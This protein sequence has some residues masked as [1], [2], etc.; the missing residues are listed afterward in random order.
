MGPLRRFLP[1]L[2]SVLVT[3]GGGV[4]AQVVPPEDGRRYAL[5]RRT[6]PLEKALIKL[7]EAGAPLSYRPDLI[8]PLALRC[9]GGRRTLDNW[10]TLLLRDTDLTYERSPAGYLIVPDPELRSKTFRL[11][12]SL[13]ERGSGEP[14]IGAAVRAVGEP[15]GPL[16]VTN[17]FG[18]YSLSLRGG[19]QRVR[20]SH[21]GYNPLEIDVVLRADS[22]LDPALGAN[23]RLPQVIVTAVPDSLTGRSQT[24][25]HIGRQ[26]ASQMAGPGGQADPLRLARLL[27]GVTSGADGV[28]GLFVRGSEAGHNLVLLDGVPV[29]NLSHAAGLF[30]IFSNEAVNRLDLYKDAVPA[31]FGGR[32]GGVLDVHTRDGNRSRNELSLGTNLLSTTVTAEGPLR[33]GRSSFLLTGRY[34]WATHLLREFSRRYKAARDR[35]GSTDYRVYDFN[36]KYSD[37]LSRRGHLYLSAYRGRDDYRNTS[38]ESDTITVLTAQ[39][40]AFRYRTPRSRSDRVGWVNTVAALRYNHIFSDRLFTNFRLSYSDLESHAVT[41]RSDSIKEVFSA[42]YTG[43]AFQG[44]YRSRIRQG[45]L[46]FDGEYGLPRAGRLTFGAAAD[47]HRFRPA[48]RTGARLPEGFGK[49]PATQPDEWARQLT[50]YASWEGH[51]GP[52]FIRAGSRVQYWKNGVG[53]LNWSPRLLLSGELSPRLSWQLAYD[54]TVQAVHLLS[55]TVI[56]LP[57]NIWVPAGAGLPP[58]RADQVSLQLDWRP[59]PDWQ[60]V[61]AGYRKDFGQLVT[62]AESGSITDWRNQ[63]SRGQGRAFGSELTLRRRRGRLRGWVSYALARSDRRFDGRVNLGRPFPFRFDRRHSVNAVGVLQLGPRWTLSLT[64]RYGSGAAYSLS[65]QSIL[66]ADPGAPDPEAPPTEVALFSERNGFRLPPNHRLDL[67]FHAEIRRGERLTHAVDLGLYNVYNRHNPIYY[68]VRSH[69]SARQEQL[70]SDREFVQVYI[71]PLLPILAYRVA[72]RGR[73]RPHAPPAEL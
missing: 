25:V 17:A 30:S 73:R 70:R 41:E 65:R 11:Y 16:A 5:P 22:L 42:V 9:P 6:L 66:I 52:L 45:G 7:T 53:Y 31:R 54:R 56:G 29:Y 23:L 46:A 57:S 68:D 10:L 26:E 47:L 35:R 33:P 63:L 34:F 44:H 36:L 8:P 43:D 72:F 13:S 27:P 62:F 48:I 60:F 20:F 3:A 50:A 24:G 14:I 19:R 67:N 61:A 71:A 49:G 4:A 15:A 39:S 18:F 32:I 28:G 51:Y 12:G 21:V 58:A 38:F 40:T 2:L 69:F 64:W 55:N 1:L 59:H 37:R